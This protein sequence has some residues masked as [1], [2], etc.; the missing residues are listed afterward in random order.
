[1]VAIVATSLSCPPLATF[2]SSDGIVEVD[3]G[4]KRVA[5]NIHRTQGFILASSKVGKGKHRSKLNVPCPRSESCYLSCR[6]AP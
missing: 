2:H 4:S 3:Q 1:M 5:A 6:T